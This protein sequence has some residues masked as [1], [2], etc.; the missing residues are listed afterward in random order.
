M[1]LGVT[2]LRGRTGHAAGR[3]LLAALYR[4]ETGRDLPEILTLCDHSHGLLSLRRNSFNASNLI[5][6]RI[7][8]FQLK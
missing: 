4:R 8:I 1:I 5:G 3:E 7:N 2:E 6:N